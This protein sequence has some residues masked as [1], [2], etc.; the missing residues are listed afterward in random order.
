MPIAG[1]LGC[2]LCPWPWFSEGE[3][4]V[5][6]LR[7]GRADSSV[8]AGLGWWRICCG[9]DGEKPGEMGMPCW[10]GN[11]DLQK[12]LERPAGHWA[13]VP[14]CRGSCVTGMG[15]PKTGML[16]WCSSGPGRAGWTGGTLLILGP[17]TAGCGGIPAQRLGAPRDGE[18]SPGPAQ[19]HATAVG[20]GDMDLILPQW[21]CRQHLVGDGGGGGG[22]NRCPSQSGW[23][24]RR[25]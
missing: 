1:R 12:L 21:L 25:H 20:R 18:A 4:S 14:L 9:V 8:M 22:A 15:L 3:L 24:R 16:S 5:P 13:V 10:E 6:G 17:K 19:S 7:A 2:C 11:W 23:G